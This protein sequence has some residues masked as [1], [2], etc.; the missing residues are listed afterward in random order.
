MHPFVF[1]KISNCMQGSFLISSIFYYTWVV[2]ESEQKIS[3]LGENEQN[4]K[5][6]SVNHQNNA[7]KY[8]SDNMESNQQHLKLKTTVYKL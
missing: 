1:F 4:K 2:V 6:I 5:A 8:E 7:I 3:R